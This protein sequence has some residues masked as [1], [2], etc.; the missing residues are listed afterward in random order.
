[1]PLIP[2]ASPP[3]DP[4]AALLAAVLDPAAARPPG[5]L[6][7]L[8]IGRPHPLRR[9]PRRRRAGLVSPSQASAAALGNLPEN[10]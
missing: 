1:M 2:W 3:P 10:R 8:L 5:Q 9:L 6:R 7:P 4:L